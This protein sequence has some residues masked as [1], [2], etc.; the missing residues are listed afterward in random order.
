[1]LIVHP[2]F[3]ANSI[4]ELVAYAKANPGKLNYAR[5]ALEPDAF[6]RRIAQRP[7]RHRRGARAV[8][9]RRRDG[10][11]GARSAGADVVSRYFDPAAL[12]AEKKI[13]GAAVTRG[14]RAIRSFRTCRPWP[15]RRRRLRPTFWT[16]VMAPAG[17]PTDI[18]T[19]SMP[20]FNFGLN[21]PEMRDSLTR[22][23]AQPASGSPADFAKFSP[24][25]RKSGA[26][27]PRR[28]VSRCR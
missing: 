26:R 18:V 23:G 14:R 24:M 3:P 17:T 4:K 19:G 9:E 28:P 8:Q 1:V 25:K 7:H 13:K 6:C 11:R 16:G 10:H 12:I 15:K 2:S 21:T 20:R 5:P 22:T 27:S